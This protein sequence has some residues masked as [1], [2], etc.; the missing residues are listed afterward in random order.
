MSKFFNETLKARST[1]LNSDG[2]AEL[3]GSAGPA[4]DTNNSI[5]EPA[6]HIGNGAVEPSAA[7]ASD[8]KGL[9][10]D[11]NSK[12]QPCISNPLREKFKGSNS[13]EA[14]DESYRAL[15]TR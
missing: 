11:E 1:A 14:V 3:L 15:R 8:L 4:A 10:S 13:L 5:R 12:I 9:L 7:P 2:I 6:T